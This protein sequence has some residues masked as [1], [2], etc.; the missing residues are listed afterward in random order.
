ML[1][2]LLQD[3][4]KTEQNRGNVLAASYHA[5]ECLSDAW[6]NMCC[7][8]IRAVF[9][10]VLVVCSK[11]SRQMM[12]LETEKWSKKAFKTTLATA[13]ITLS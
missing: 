7:C 1:H 12:P 13:L 9:K 5:E 8:N 6:F 2:A 3:R 11:H 10:V 4:S